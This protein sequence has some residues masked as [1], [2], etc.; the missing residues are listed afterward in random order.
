MT[1]NGPSQLRIFCLCGQKMKVG[2]DMYGRPGKC[3]ACRQK[4][5][6]PSADEVPPGTTEVHL[7]DHPEFL[8]KTLHRADAPPPPVTPVPAEPSIAHDDDETGTVPLDV[9]EAIR[10]LCSA[11]YKIARHLA[12]WDETADGAP[13]G[14][15]P[16]D[17]RRLR[18][19][20]EQVRALRAELNEELRQRLMEVAIELASTQEKIAEAALSVR[21]GETNFWSYRDQVTKLRRR[22]D[23]LERRQENLRG[24]SAVRDP[25]GAGGFVEVNLDALPKSGIRVALPTEMDESQPALEWHLDAL[26]RGF[27]RRE[28]AERKLAESVAL[29]EEGAAGTLGL[30]GT[31]AQYEADRQRSLA[32]ILFTRDR[33]TQV[34]E[35]CTKDTQSLDAQVDLLRGRLQ[36]GE[37]HRSHFNTQERRLLRLKSDL[38]KATD[39]ADRALSANAHQDVPQLRGT[40]AR[41]LAGADAAAAGTPTESWIAWGAA[42]GMLVSLLLPGVGGISPLRALREFGSQSP[43]L[44]WLAS[45]PVLMAV[46]VASAALLPRRGL[47]GIALAAVWVLAA[48]TFG[49][50]LHEKGYSPDAYGR[51]L[52][53]DD[54]WFVRP[55]LLLYALSLIALAASACVALAT[56]K[57]LWWALPVATAAVLLW[58]GAV[59]TDFGGALIPRPWLH[60]SLGDRLV[61]GTVPA[62]V[63]LEN[64]GR[65]TLYVSDD[66]T[67]P[68][69]CQYAMETQPPGESWRNVRPPRAIETP[70]DFT[71]F[72]GTRM[73]EFMA[74]APGTATTLHYALGGGSYRVILRSRLL[75]ADREEAFTIEPD[76]INAPDDA[77]T[78]EPLPA[79]R[80]TIPGQP[81]SGP[82]TAPGAPTPSTEARPIE[83]PPVYVPPEGVT[84]PLLEGKTEVALLAILRNPQNQTRFSITVYYPDGDSAHRT[85]GMDEEVYRGWKLAEYN[86]DQLTVTLTYEDELLVLRRGERNT[87]PRLAPVAP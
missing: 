68:N 6:I 26:R 72:G 50:Y 12:M 49:T 84:L 27:A 5:R 19:R 78:R 25:H 45:G 24:W 29:A 10:V 4:I 1:E 9:L 47:R 51:L 8:R 48:T 60:V 80:P 87:L 28:L 76:S 55:G 64:R 34:R 44:L 74:V 32:E 52:R 37:M 86:P 23:L 39:L 43:D 85:V 22:R 53:G 56:S 71:P 30:E 46:V 54:A 16:T 42:A 18:E 83:Q 21:V 7:K 35:D 20:H 2:S 70:D 33:L 17:E 63:T 66:T 13:N 38:A 73:P 15:Q 61:D 57:R 67:L 3:V 77:S 65:R 11:D 36:I 31:R 59:A 40:F 75:S 81:I 41:R 69:G 79:P 14:Q 58:M 62:S 82:R